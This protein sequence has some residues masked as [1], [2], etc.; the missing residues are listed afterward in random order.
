MYFIDQ[1]YR[2]KMGACLGEWQ[3]TCCSYS[4]IVCICKTDICISWLINLYTYFR[5]DEWSESKNGPPTDREHYDGP[6]GMEVD[7]IIQSNWDEVFWFK[8]HFKA[9]YAISATLRMFRITNCF[10]KYRIN[11]VADVRGYINRSLSVV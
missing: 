3:N 8:I 7:G 10:Q 4:F 6:P 2:C 1:L 11:W 9:K 5:N